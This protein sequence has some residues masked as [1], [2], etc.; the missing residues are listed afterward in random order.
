MRLTRQWVK[1]SAPPAF[2]RPLL[3]R[4]DWPAASLPAGSS[5][6]HGRVDSLTPGA[7]AP[8]DDVRALERLVACHRQPAMTGD[9]SSPRA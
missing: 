2:T 4:Q 8:S 6:G 1:A 7:L 5:L 9:T 3:R